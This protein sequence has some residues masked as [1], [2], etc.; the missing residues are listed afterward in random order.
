[1]NVEATQIHCPHCHGVQT[2]NDTGNYECD[3]CLQ[4]FSV[5]QAESEAQ[6]LKEE[7]KGWLQGKIGAAAVSSSGVDEAS[8]AYIFQDKI[9]PDLRRDVDRSLET[10]GS[11]GQFPLVPP[12][13][14]VEV[15]S[16]PGA[17]PLV[18]MR[19]EILALKGLRARL[20]DMQITAFAVGD[21]DRAAVQEMDRRIADFM[22]L[23]NVAAAAAQRSSDGYNSARR[24][25]ESVIGE[26][27]Q[28]IALAGAQNPAHAT[29]LGS[30]KERYQ[31]LTEYCRIC[32]ELC[33]PNAVSG[34][35]INE[36]LG[37]LGT[38]LNT[39]ART[40]EAMDYNPAD[41]M[42]LVVGIDA[43]VAATRLLTRWTSA[44]ETLA[45]NLQLP[46]LNFIVEMDPF[47]RAGGPT[48]TAQADVLEG[49]ATVIEAARGEVAVHAMNDYG[50]VDGWVEAGRAKKWLGLFGNEEQ[51]ASVHKFLVPVWVGDVSFTESTGTVFKEGVENRALALVDACAPSAGNVKL[52]TDMAAPVAMAMQTEQALP[53]RELALPMSTATAVEPMMNQALRNSPQLQ[54]ARVKL[55]GLAYLPTAVVQYQSPKGDREAAACM[56]NLLRVDAGTKLHAQAAQQL[57]Q[58]FG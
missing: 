2:P 4:P 16:S 45:R 26:V 18:T 17:N 19:N 31:G 49:Y 20:T 42:P 56:G 24:N 38:Q 48:P 54:N 30:V 46:F 44:Y 37:R 34:A 35:A 13:I 6:R 40:V 57:I 5:Q 51:A 32:E 53:S 22:H 50:W 41:T 10:L 14:A 15:G 29:F 52:V 25:L 23:S 9:L 21:Q 27:D 8:R 12:P 7:I 36:R 43:E 3:F 1:M 47:V 58:R 11:F 28:S 55:R 33:S 39:V